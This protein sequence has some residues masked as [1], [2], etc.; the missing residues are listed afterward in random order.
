MS[1]A[2]DAALHQIPAERQAFNE[3]RSVVLGWYVARHD[4]D[5]YD[6]T[7]EYRVGLFDAATG[8]LLTF[9]VTSVHERADTGTR[10]GEHLA[11]A[12]FDPADEYT[13]V[14]RYRDGSEQRCAVDEHVRELKNMED[15]GVVVS[16]AEKRNRE[17]LN[18]DREAL[19][20]KL[21]LKLKPRL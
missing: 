8:E 20:R 6:E 4:E 1:R 15:Y 16:D 14:L 13:V 17:R 21:E 18:R 19:R 7:T 10:E 5:R 3:D 12:A 2:L 9:F 11:S